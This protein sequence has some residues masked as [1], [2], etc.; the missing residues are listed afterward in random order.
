MPQDTLSPE[1]IKEGLHTRF[2]GRNMIFYPVL[3]STMDAAREAAIKGATEGTLVIADEQT[4]GRGRLRRA[5]LSPT[6]CLTFSLI[7][8]PETR[9]LPF[10]VMASALAV[11]DTVEAATAV[12]P[13]IKWPNDVLAGGKKISGILIETGICEGRSGYAV[14][15]IGLNV[16]LDP[17]GCPGISD[18]ATSLSMSAGK[19]FSRAAVLIELLA[20]LESRY[21]ELVTGA[22]VFETWRLRLSTLGK[23][24]KVKTGNEIFEGRA[25]DVASDGALMLRLKNGLLLKLPAGDVTLNPKA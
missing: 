1:L 7:L 21:E 8:Y 17:A 19:Y 25:E 20:R 11:A 23:D 16:N 9:L 5:W 14:I 12:K 18:T 15:G 22:P 4:A 6:G 2:I 13:D 24:V 10:L 3:T